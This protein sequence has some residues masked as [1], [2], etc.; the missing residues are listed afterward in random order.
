MRTH[1]YEVLF[2]LSM[3]YFYAVVVALSLFSSEV[4]CDDPG[5]IDQ[6]TNLKAQASQPANAQD[7]KQH[8]IEDASKQIAAILDK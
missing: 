6:Q 5:K 2:Q 8:T 7:L 3:L 1:Q 4:A